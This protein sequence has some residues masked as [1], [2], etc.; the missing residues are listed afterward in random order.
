MPRNDKNNK[1]RTTS[2]KEIL[3]KIINHRTCKDYCEL[4]I[5]DNLKDIW[6]KLFVYLWKKVPK[7]YLMLEKFYMQ[8][9]VL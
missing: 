2:I 3:F 9:I 4:A 1:W 6:R 7:S 8:W 5:Q